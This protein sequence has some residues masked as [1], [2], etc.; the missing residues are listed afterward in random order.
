MEKSFKKG[1]VVTAKKTSDGGEV[2]GKFGGYR[3]FNDERPDSVIGVVYAP[4]DDSY[5]VEADSIQYFESDNEKVRKYLIEWVGNS[6]NPRKEECLDYLEKVVNT[7]RAREFADE[8]KSICAKYQ[9]MGFFTDKRAISFLNDVKVACWREC[10]QITEEEFRLMSEKQ[11][12][13][14][15]IPDSVKF[16][17]GFKTGREL[18]FREGVESVKPAEWSEEDNIGWDEAFACVTRAEKAAKNEEELQNAVTAEKWLKEIKFKYYVHPVKKEWSD[19]DSDNLE[20]VDNYLYMLDNYIGDDCATPQAKADKIRRNIQEVL[21]PW[22]KSLPERFNLQPKQEWSDEDEKSFNN[23]LDGLR[24]TYED[25]INNKSFDSAADIKNAFEWMRSRFKCFNPQND[26]IEEHCDV[27]EEYSEEPITFYYPE[28]P[29]ETEVV[30]EGNSISLRH[31]L[32]KD[33]KF[34]LKKTNG[35]QQTSG[36]QQVPSNFIKELEK[37]KKRHE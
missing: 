15:C 17:E 5:E 11:K 31:K 27:I 10:G 32:D 9:A 13:V 18:G 29:Y 1:E 24:Y 8:I 33:G 23:V 14:E 3:L 6:D 26:A 36:T 20:R 16:N 2:I 22:L 35:T 25:L 28:D 12:P 19:E 21:S 7:L 4:G 30:Q 34:V 37:F